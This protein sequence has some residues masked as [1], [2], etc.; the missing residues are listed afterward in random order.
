MNKDSCYKQKI[1]YS[2]ATEVPYSSG[3]VLKLVLL[4]I[5]KGL[6]TLHS[7]MFTGI[8]RL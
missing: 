8:T 4:I 7:V 2:A 6:P 3:E 1:F 5:S